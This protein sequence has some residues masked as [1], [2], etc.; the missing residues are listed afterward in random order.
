M[1]CLG[2]G[3]AGWTKSAQSVPM[4][5]RLR[6]LSLRSP[7]LPT[8]GPIDLDL[9]AWSGNTN[10]VHKVTVSDQLYE[11]LQKQAAEYPA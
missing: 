3:L 5:G 8:F 6:Q 4:I 10:G 9:P 1:N 2:L 7:A 11:K